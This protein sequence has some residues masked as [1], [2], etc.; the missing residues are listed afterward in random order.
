MMSLKRR[1]AEAAAPQDTPAPETAD[2][3]G[4]AAPG[5]LSPQVLAVFDSIEAD[6]RGLLD[7]IRTA[8]DE[9]AGAV[10]NVNGSL[11]SIRERTGLLGQV[12]EETRS[13]ADQLESATDELR[14]A[15]REIAD[16]ARA[17]TSYADA[18]SGAAGRA[19]ETA[20]R[21]QSSSADI[22]KV[23]GVISGIAR[24]TNLLALNATIEAARAGEAGR[25]FAV[26]ASEV[27][28]LSRETQSATETIGAQ[29]SG[30]QADAR[31][32][33]DAMAEIGDTLDRVRPVFGAVAAAVEEQISSIGELVRTAQVTAQFVR[34]VVES[35]REIDEAVRR[36]SSINAAS[37]VSGRAIDKF[38][39]R[40]MVVL[41]QNDLADRRQI[42]RLPVEV[43]VSLRHGA[44][45][46]GGRTVDVS[47]GGA[48][49]AGGGVD[50]VPVGAEVEATIDRVGAV[51]ARVVGRTPTGLHLQ[52]TGFRGDASAGLDRLLDA[53]AEENRDFVE[54]ATTAA[55]AI[56]RQL[57]A[58]IDS[59]RL[60][61]AQL[62]DTEYTPIAGTDPLQ[63]STGY[64]D[65]LE[66]FLPQ[67]QEPL[68]AGDPRMVFCAATD[69]N[70]YLP[71][72][73]RKF[74]QPQKPGD[75]AW[76]AANARNRRIFDD[77]A[78]L[79]A[80]RNTRPF[81]V[82]SYPRDMGNGTVVM[83]KEVDAPIRV[84]GR[85]WGCFRT[86][87]RL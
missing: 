70:G 32:T 83:M 72:H 74:S 25:G 68:L 6:L 50:A 54:R 30:L 46:H 58:L 63:L 82:Q 64:L 38:I 56:G 13:T 55:A 24:Q 79:A 37:E 19:A 41:R 57:E 67:I 81:L 73:N 17:A 80:A 35:S 44:D 43:P 76:N 39:T 51:T 42:D 20:G 75:P 49:Y 61:E 5:G 84:R 18:A 14:G 26:V 10:R 9:I 34:A 59:G 86:A 77:R 66:G 36:A 33:I 3:A 7:G 12:A 48:L 53:I 16:Q 65:A 87:Y 31:A 23:V 15:S 71:V 52:F 47:R 2:P 29:I 22:G 40:V 78:G 85:H 4:A 62:F 28:A 1:P 21:L 27:K 45:V 69:R 60:T 11:E 8:S